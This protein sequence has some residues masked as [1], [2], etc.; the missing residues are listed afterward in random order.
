M[1]YESIALEK[2]KLR[3][4]TF[5]MIDFRLTRAFPALKRCDKCQHYFVTNQREIKT[6][7]M[8]R[9]FNLSSPQNH[10]KATEMLRPMQLFGQTT[11]TFI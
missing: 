8:T 3:R 5:Q 9:N 11:K 2:D 6:K 10:F 7:V 1:K 4:E